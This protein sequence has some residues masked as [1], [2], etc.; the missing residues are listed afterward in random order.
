VARDPEDF[1]RVPGKFSAL[2]NSVRGMRERTGRVEDTP[3]MVEGV[4][5]KV[6][7]VDPSPRP[8]GGTGAVASSRTTGD[9]ATEPWLPS[10]KGAG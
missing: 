10:F 3:G 2:V 7:D 8:V 1:L 4:H 5:R 6:E 9:V